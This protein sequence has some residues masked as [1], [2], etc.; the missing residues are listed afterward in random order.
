[1]HTFSLEE[2]N[3]LSEGSDNVS[4]APRRGWFFPTHVCPESV[5]GPKKLALLMGTHPRLGRESVFAKYSTVDLKFALKNVF[6]LAGLLETEG[7][8]IH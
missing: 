8:R 3:A 4:I 1:M 2:Y 5:T 6:Q 7:A